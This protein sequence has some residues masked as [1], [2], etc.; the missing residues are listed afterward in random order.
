M[1]ETQLLLP[2]GM[3]A[4]AGVEA[5]TMTKSLEFAYRSAVEDIHIVMSL[6]GQN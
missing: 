6:K 4:A 2:A 1:A 3:V 5:K